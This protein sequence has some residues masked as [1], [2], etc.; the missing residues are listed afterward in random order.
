MT[1]FINLTPHDITVVADGR[2]MKI[3]ASGQVARVATTEKVVGEIDGIPIIK[4]EF[5]EIENLPAPTGGTV[6]IVSSL[7][8]SA[9]KNRTDVVAPDTG[10]TAVRDDKGQIVAVTRFVTA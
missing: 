1:K 8:L 6:F 10:A 2:E 3:P 5:G 7:V 9:V 4:R